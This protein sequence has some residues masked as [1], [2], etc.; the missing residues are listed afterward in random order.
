M[1]EKATHDGKH[2]WVVF[3]SSPA[4][5]WVGRGSQWDDDDW[6]CCA[7][8]VVSPGKGQGKYLVISDNDPV[9]TTVNS[10]ITDVLF[11]LQKNLWKTIRGSR[12]QLT[13]L[14]NTD[15]SGLGSNECLKLA[16]EKVLEWSRLTEIELSRL[17]GPKFE[18]FIKLTKC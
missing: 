16:S 5:N 1:F 6:H 10:R 15:R 4:S 3:C 11:G 7:A 8:I 18:G 17:Y 13:V 12:K 9:K 2:C 14:Y